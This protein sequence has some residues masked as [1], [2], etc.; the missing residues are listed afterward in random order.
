MRAR[1]LTPFISVVLVLALA[2]LATAAT[3]R[4]FKGKTS[5]NSSIAFSLKSR[6]ITHMHFNITLS[7]SDGD[8]QPET[9]SGFERIRVNS[10]NRFSDH[11][12]GKTDDVRT[13]GK[14][15]GARVTGTVRVTDKIS[16]TV[17]CGPGSATFTATRVKAK[18]KK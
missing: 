12:V 6:T 14:V 18:K 11:Q 17:T 13:T 4:T 16:K 7:C 10:K 5:Q 8:T 2:G 9:L 1:R 15:K 3:S